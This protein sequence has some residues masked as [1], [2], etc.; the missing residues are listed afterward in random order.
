MREMNSFA[1]V[2]GTATD[3]NNHS[4]QLPTEE[5][6]RDWSFRVSY[7]KSTNK[8]AV[9]EELIDIVMADARGYETVLK[10]HGDFEQFCYRV[11]APLAILDKVQRR[12]GLRFQSVFNDIL[13][14]RIYA[15]SYLDTAPPYLR[16]VDLTLGKDDDDGY[17]AQHLYYKRDNSSYIIEIQIWAGR[18]ILFNT[19]SHELSYKYIN[20]PALMRQVHEKYCNGM[21]TSRE[22]F[23]AEVLGL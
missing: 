22:E 11:K 4:V 18:D 9:T 1:V 21:I 13:G 19:W 7:T 3:N 5:Q 8:L 20:N 2:G 6:L 10:S 23:R 16:M 15:D 17:R 12:P 14:I